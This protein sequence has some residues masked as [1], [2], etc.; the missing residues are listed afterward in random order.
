MNRMAHPFSSADITIFSVFAILRHK[1]ID[2]IL[3]DNF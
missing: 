1:D 3:V 2:W